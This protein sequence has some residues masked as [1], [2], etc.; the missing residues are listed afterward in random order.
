[1]PWVSYVLW[2][3]KFWSMTFTVLIYDFP[4]ISYTYIFKDTLY[5][6]WNLGQIQNTDWSIVSASQ[7]YLEFWKVPQSGKPPLKINIEIA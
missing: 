1:V 7:E 6:V 3:P 2:N 4:C 5:T